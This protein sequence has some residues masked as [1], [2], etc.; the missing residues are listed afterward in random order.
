MGT[1]QRSKSS[2]IAHICLF[3]NDLS[4]GNRR[5]AGRNFGLNLLGIPDRPAIFPRPYVQYVASLNER[6]DAD[7]EEPS[8]GAP[9]GE[10]LV[11]ADDTLWEIA[12]AHSTSV[13]RIRPGQV[14]T[15]PAGQ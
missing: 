14:L 8:N 5:E 12:Q 13:D 2:R 4:R 15:V 10:Q 6:R 7:Q 11:H 9:A 1:S 3:Y